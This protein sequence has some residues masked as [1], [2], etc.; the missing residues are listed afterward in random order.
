MPKNKMSDLRDHLFETIELLKD[1]E[2]G[3]DVKKAQAIADIGR[4]LVDTARAEISYIKL[5][6]AGGS[7]FLRSKDLPPLVSAKPVKSLSGVGSESHLEACLNC[8]L[9]ECDENSPKCLIQIQRQAA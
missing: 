5:A 8:E 2:S 9:P 1:E 6:G 4:V 3:M 7:E